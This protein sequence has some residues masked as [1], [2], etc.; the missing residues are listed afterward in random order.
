MLLTNSPSASSLLLPISLN[1]FFSE[2][3]L[4]LLLL[5]LF[6]LSLFYSELI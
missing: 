3:L 6:L 5:P 1:P 2:F 4:I